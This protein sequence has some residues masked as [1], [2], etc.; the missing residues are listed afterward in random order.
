MSDPESGKRMTPEMERLVEDYLRRLRRGLRG[1]SSEVAEEAELEI[2]AHVEDGLAAMEN[3]DRDRLRGLLERLGRP[4][5]LGRDMALYMMVDRGYHDWSL[6]HM[7][8]STTFWAL[9]TVAGAVVVLIFGALYAIALGLAASGG[10]WWIERAGLLGTGAVASWVR[11]RLDPMGFGTA[12]AALLLGLLGGLLLGAMVRWFVGQYL[13]HAGPQLGSDDAAGDE[14]AWARRAERRILVVAAS[15]FALHLL[16]GLAAG[17]YGLRQTPGPGFDPILR[18]EFTASPMALLS[19]LGL[20]VL[21]LAP[22]IGAL[23]TS[24]ES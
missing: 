19:G 8:R 20:S 13:R 14:S 17:I 7:L 23:M 6:P 2:R 16:A 10:L 4:E 12:S 18:P 15:G 24:H 11:L 5:E 21:A 9:S 22:I 3:A 1:A